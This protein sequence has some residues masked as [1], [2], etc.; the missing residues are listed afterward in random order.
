MASQTPSELSQTPSEFTIPKV[1]HP[2]AALTF[3]P[4]PQ[5]SAALTFPELEGRAEAVED[6]FGK[7][8][9]GVC[10]DGAGCGSPGRA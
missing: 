5:P 6:T 2:S 4:Q 3:P 10:D 8:T 1:P 9:V 7:H